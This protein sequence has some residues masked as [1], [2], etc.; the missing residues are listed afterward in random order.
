MAEEESPDVWNDILSKVVILNRMTVPKVNQDGSIL[1]HPSESGL[2]RRSIGEMHGQKSDW[3]A[4]IAGSDRGVHVQEFEDCY[5]IHVDR[6]DPHKKPLQHIARDSPTTGAA[7]ALA[8][9]GLII[10]ARAITRARKKR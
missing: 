7:L 8:G 3:R 1:P 2:F 6:Y 4:S 10:A 9:L 5:K